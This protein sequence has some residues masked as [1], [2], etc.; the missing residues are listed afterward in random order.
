MTPPCCRTST[1]GRKVCA[2]RSTRTKST[3]C[4]LKPSSGTFHIYLDP[5]EFCP[6]PLVTR[7]LAPFLL[8]TPAFLFWH[9]ALVAVQF[10]LRHLPGHE[11]ERGLRVKSICKVCRVWPHRGYILSV[12]HRRKAAVLLVDPTRKPE[13]SDGMPQQTPPRDGQIPTNSSPKVR[14]ISTLRAVI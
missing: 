9:R 11:A 13:R 10:D 6:H 14:I 5:I 3:R 1:R 2:R 8:L 7:E 12:S 4:R